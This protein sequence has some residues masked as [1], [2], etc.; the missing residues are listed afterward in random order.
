MIRGVAAS[1]VFPLRR[2]RNP[3]GVTL[4]IGVEQA[5][6]EWV[7]VGLCIEEN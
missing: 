2:I 4:Y 3:D 6:G 1:P 7:S 5:R